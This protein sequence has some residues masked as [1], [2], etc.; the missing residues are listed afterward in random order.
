MTTMSTV[1]EADYN[2]NKCIV[3]DTK[4]EPINI[5]KTCKKPRHSRCAGK[6]RGGLSDLCHNNK[7]QTIPP[8]TMMKKPKDAPTRNA[9]MKKQARDS[10]TRTT[11]NKTPPSKYHHTTAT[12]KQARD[13]H[14]RTTTKKTPPSK[15]PPYHSDEKTSSGLSNSHYTE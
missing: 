12:K 8:A 1:N 10:H 3:C 2:S 14:T 5:C 13:S 7:K 6:K 4:D 11:P 15:I 9:T